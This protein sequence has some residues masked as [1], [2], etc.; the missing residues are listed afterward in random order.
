M[1]NSTLQTLI[2][3][4]IALAVGFF[5]GK[6][7]SS[8][9]SPAD[10]T[11][12]KVAQLT[13]ESEDKEEATVPEASEATTAPDSTEQKPITE[14]PKVE[15]K[16]A[17]P[18]TSNSGIILPPVNTGISD[19]RISEVL[20]SIS[21]NMQDQ[22]LAYNKKIGQDCSGIYHRLKDSLKVQLPSL[23]AAEY[24]YPLFSKDRSSRQIA[25]WYYEN[26]NL[27]IIEDAVASKNS[28][29]PG[30]VLF[31]GQSEKRFKNI[32]IDRLTDRKNNYTQNGIIEH[33]AVVTSIRT[34]K[35]GNLKDYMMMHARY[36]GGPHASLSGSQEIQSTNTPDLPPF[37]HWEQQLVA[38]ANIVTL[39]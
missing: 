30:S 1:K 6:S 19:K 22:K 3:F 14:V 32:T 15:P 27:L 11:A 39:K 18:L 4:V 10:T 37:G 8:S 5:I 13:E 31:F 38:V 33:V 20:T 35:E 25:D 17:P 21:K 28:I 7:F 9:A 34:D 2:A 16:P 26:G 36:P 29:R 24:H 23:Q 12:K